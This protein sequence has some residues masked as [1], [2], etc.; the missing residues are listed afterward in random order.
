[1]DEIWRSID[2]LNGKYEVSNLGR[3]RHSKTKRVRKLSKSKRGYLVF[4]CYPNGTA[5]KQKLVNVHRCVALVFLP[6]PM[7]LPQVNHIDGNKLNPNVENLEWVSQRDNAI[8]ARRTGLHK[9][10][11]DR[12]VV[13]IE[14]GK[15]IA[16]YKSASEASRATGISRSGICQVCNHFVYKGRHRLSAGGYKWEWKTDDIE[17][18]DGRPQES[19]VLS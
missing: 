9:S 2:F 7:G 3:I 1:M 6:N 4:S 5:G 17:I 12:P 16:E 11:G 15:V 19:T 13:Q 14:A 8:H 10:D 18:S